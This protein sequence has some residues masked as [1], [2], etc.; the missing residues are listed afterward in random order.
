MKKKKY[1]G[2]DV[3]SISAK[4]ARRVGDRLGV[5]WRVIDLE[6]FRQGLEIEQEH[7]DIVGDNIYDW[8]RITIAH[9]LEVPDY[10]TKLRKYVDPG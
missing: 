1:A 9:L 8:G 5:D 7:R 2:F 4:E 10:N 3:R 6:E